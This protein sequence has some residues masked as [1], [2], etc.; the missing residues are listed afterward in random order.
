VVHQMNARMTLLT[1]FLES[2]LIATAS[3]SCALKPSELRALKDHGPVA[4]VKL[5]V[6]GGILMDMRARLWLEGW[7]DEAKRVGRRLEGPASSPT[8]SRGAKT[9]VLETMTSRSWLRPR[10][11]R[12]GER[13]GRV[14]AGG[15]G[16]G[17][18]AY[19]GVQGQD[20][21]L[22]REG[23]CQAQANSQRSPEE[24]EFLDD[25]AAW[26]TYSGASGADEVFCF[27]KSDGTIVRLTGRSVR[28]E[29]K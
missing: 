7:S 17:P 1:A 9:T 23:G 29:I 26:I 11:E 20:G 22:Q 13:A 5:P 21:K 15:L 4:T 10:Q 25:L 18:L 2:S 12:A 14:A 6:C 16:R 3:T 27:R 24:A 8:V 28:D 19:S